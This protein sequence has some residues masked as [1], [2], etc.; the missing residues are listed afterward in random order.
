MTLDGLWIGICI[1]AVLV[2]AFLGT[3]AMV[4]WKKVDLIYYIV[5]KKKW[6]GEH[7]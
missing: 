6:D 5:K 1:V 4:T 7:E 2:S 3:L